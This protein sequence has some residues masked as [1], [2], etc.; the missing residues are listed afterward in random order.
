M[1]LWSLVF[2]ALG[3]DPLLATEFDLRPTKA[4]A[5]LTDRQISSVTVLCNLSVGNVLVLLQC[6]K[7]AVVCVCELFMRSKCSQVQWNILK[8]RMQFPAW[9][10][11]LIPTGCAATDKWVNT[12]INTDAGECNHNPAKGCLEE[13]NPSRILH[14]TIPACLVLCKT[15]TF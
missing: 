12:Q 5:K 15:E 6:P 7:M 4:L 9:P 13:K 3:S 8:M 14:Q 1:I 2:A 11:P 10:S